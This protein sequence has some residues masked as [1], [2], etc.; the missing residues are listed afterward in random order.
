MPT[1]PRAERVVGLD[2]RIAARSAGPGRRER[3]R[4]SLCRTGAR[5]RRRPAKGPPTSP[6]SRRTL[7]SPANTKVEPRHRSDH[8]RCT[9]NVF[10]EER[11]QKRRD[12][13]RLAR[14]FIRKEPRRGSPLGN[15][16]SVFSWKVEPDGS[17]VPSFL[18][19]R[20]RKLLLIH[21]RTLAQRNAVGR[22]RFYEFPTHP[23][24][25]NADVRHL[26]EA[27]GAQGGQEHGADT[28]SG[29]NGVR[30]ATAVDPPLV[31]L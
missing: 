1:Q 31:W 10:L 13:I 9:V 16:G 20:Q 4:P 26:D 3:R 19:V 25:E 6:E 14:L 23:P 21:K 29:A 18:G 11:E 15:F 2:P 7:Q 17:R 22:G 12:G 27:T 28:L 24:S 8:L 5:G 30:T